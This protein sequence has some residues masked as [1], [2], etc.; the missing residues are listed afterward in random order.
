[1]QRNNRQ[2]RGPEGDSLKTQRDRDSVQ[3]PTQGAAP[4]RKGEYTLEELGKAETG[5]KIKLQTSCSWSKE[6]TLHKKP[7]PLASE[8]MNMFQ[9]PKIRIFNLSINLWLKFTGVSHQGIRTST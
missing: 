7:S 4:R 2:S 8:S 3:E 6:Q 5:K 1:M 9:L